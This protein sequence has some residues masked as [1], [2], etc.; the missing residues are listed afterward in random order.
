MPLEKLPPLPQR[1]RGKI[2][3]G[4]IRPPTQRSS[5]RPV[6]KHMD[7]KDEQNADGKWIKIR[8]NEV[9]KDFDSLKTAHPW[10]RKTAI[11]IGGTLFRQMPVYVK[12]NEH[13]ETVL[14]CTHE[15]RQDGREHGMYVPA[16]HLH[17]DIVVCAYH[18]LLHFRFCRSVICQSLKA[19][20]FVNFL[21]MLMRSEDAYREHLAIHQ[22][23]EDNKL[24]DNYRAQQLSIDRYNRRRWLTEL[25]VEEWHINS[26][27]GIENGYREPAL[28]KL[29]SVARETL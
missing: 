1:K 4:K 15:S 25:G 9:T 7:F 3:R 27:A 23:H 17:D 2:L 5:Q 22:R 18:A 8:G 10:E 26:P 13:K 24:T 29:S 14:Y 16:I 12:A 11:E 19:H 21:T 20:G 28:E 6:Q